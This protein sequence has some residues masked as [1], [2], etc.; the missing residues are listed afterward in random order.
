M[1]GIVSPQPPIHVLAI[2]ASLWYNL[3]MDM[4]ILEGEIV[5][6]DDDE[7]SPIDAKALYVTLQVFQITVTDNLSFKDACD[8]IGINYRTFL[9][10]FK[11]GVVQEH[12]QQDLQTL[13]QKTVG[14]AISGWVPSLRN[15]LSIS[16]GQKGTP[17]AQIRAFKELKELIG[18]TRPSELIAP[19]AQS[20]GDFLDIAQDLPIPSDLAFDS[21]GPPEEIKEKQLKVPRL[22]KPKLE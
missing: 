1:F 3:A 19:I 22:P 8:Q 20:W 9:R 14:M 4:E 10:Y 13:S 18:L 5:D 11:R 2:F 15:L 7:L 16:T 12:L 17:N 21:E 6:D